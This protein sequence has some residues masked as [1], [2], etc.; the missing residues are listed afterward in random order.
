[1]GAH[2]CVLYYQIDDGLVIASTGADDSYLR[3]PRYITTFDDPLV[4]VSMRATADAKE[5]VVQFFQYNGT[6]YSA[7]AAPLNVPG[8]RW[9][10]VLVIPTG[11]F[12][13]SLDESLAQVL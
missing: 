10:L 4:R 9:Q 2:C 8:L 13:A 11:Y 3:T 1:M 12:T 7:V 6:D 5:A